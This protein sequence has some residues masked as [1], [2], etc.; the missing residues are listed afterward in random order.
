MDRTDQ[1]TAALDD[2]IRHIAAS[3]ERLKGAAFKDV[4]GVRLVDAALYEAMEALARAAGP[5][6]SGKV[7][8]MAPDMP[9]PGC[10][11]I[12]LRRFH[13]SLESAEWLST[14]VASLQDG[15]AA[16][17]SLDLVAALNG[18]KPKVGFVSHRRYRPRPPAGRM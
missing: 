8:V 13:C 1:F 16:R 4:A 6:R 2:A 17:K 18:E 10:V 14:L 9:P 7:S 3:R 15:A 5:L 12:G 11:D